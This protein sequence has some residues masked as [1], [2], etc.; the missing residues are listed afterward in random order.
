MAASTTMTIR[1]TPETKQK[2]ERIAADTRRS[3]SFL[4]AEAL[5]AYVDREIEFID[6]IE[7]GMADVKAG[8]TVPH[9]QVMKEA[10]RIAA[11]VRRKNAAGR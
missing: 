5:S 3:K 4:A 10:R 1:V 2:L 9:E 7:R 8:R 11:D 6:G